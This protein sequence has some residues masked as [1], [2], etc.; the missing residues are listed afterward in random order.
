MTDR[1]RSV[2]NCILFIIDDLFPGFDLHLF[3]IGLL[4][5]PPC[6]PTGPVVYSIYRGE[7]VLI[8]HVLDAVVSSS[9]SVFKKYHWVAVKKKRPQSL[10]FLLS[11]LSD[12]CK[13]VC[14]LEYSLDSFGLRS[15]RDIWMQ[16]PIDGI[17]R[18][19]IRCG[20]VEKRCSRLDCCVPKLWL[21]SFVSNS[22]TSESFFHFLCT[23]YADCSSALP[24]ICCNI[25]RGSVVGRFNGFHFFLQLVSLIIESLA[26]AKRSPS[27][28]KCWS[29]GICLIGEE[30]GNFD[31]WSS[32]RMGRAKYN[33]KNKD[34]I[35][36]T[37]SLTISPDYFSFLS[38]LLLP[39]CFYDCILR[40]EQ[41]EI[42][43]RLQT[44]VHVKSQVLLTA[45]P[46]NTQT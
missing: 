40:F 42:M 24:Q 45:L 2:F 5:T 25:R 36:A 6:S 46:Y 15:V 41:K 7:R 34:C 23:S 27:F 28:F 3:F 4:P 44:C 17:S 33:E 26:Y 14:G 9:S 38:I 39:Q 20:R 21:Q 19:T 35:W 8:V 31:L 43:I 11:K 10:P 22:R 13:G 29:N 1:A 12:V 37:D 30:N 32:G 16:W 18:D